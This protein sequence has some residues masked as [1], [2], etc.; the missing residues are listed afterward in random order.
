VGLAAALVCLAGTVGAASPAVRKSVGEEGVVKELHHAKHLLEHADHDYDGHRARAV[1]DVS[2]AIHEL[3]HGASHHHHLEAKGK[4]GEELKQTK[5]D[6][7]LKEALAILH[8]AKTQLSK[9]EHHKKALHHVEEAIHQIHT[10]LK[11]N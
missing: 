11:V 8:E 3:S 7:H 6:E 1:K 4:G 5:S 2:E 10:A 9:H